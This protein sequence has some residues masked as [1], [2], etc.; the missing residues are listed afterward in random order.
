MK[1]YLMAIAPIRQNDQNGTL[2]VDRQQQKSYFT[3]QVL[4][5]PQAERW[6]LWMLIIS[7]VLVTPYWLLK[8]FVTLPR[9]IIHNPAL[10]WLILF[11]TAG[12]PILAWIFGRQKQ[13]YDAK[14]LI[15]LTVDV[16][17]L[18]KQLQKWPFERAW[19]L[20]VL[21][22]LPPTALMFLVL[23]IIKADVVDALLI[24]V[25]G[26]LFMRRLIPHA[27]SRIRV[28]TKQIIEWR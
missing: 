1:D 26:A 27:I 24:T 15:P 8:Y 18:T 13:G 21:T 12:L 11:L 10:W 28:S 9:I 4:P 16:S 7:G 5:E 6:L 20:F 22:L 14:Q 23:Y 19:V 25:H 17:D 2:I 3:P